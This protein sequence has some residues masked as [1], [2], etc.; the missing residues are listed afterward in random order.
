MDK[1]APK[2]DT[3]YSWNSEKLDAMMRKVNKHSIYNYIKKAILKKKLIS[4][5][6]VVTG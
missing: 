1:E 3:P 6:K 2:E 5:S 4:Y